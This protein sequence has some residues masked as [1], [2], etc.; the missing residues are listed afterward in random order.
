MNSTDGR[1][2]GYSAAASAYFDES[3]SWHKAGHDGL[4]GEEKE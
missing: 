2:D 1:K 4:I 3:A